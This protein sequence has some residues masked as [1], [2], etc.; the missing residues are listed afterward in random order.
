MGK[1]ILVLG[2]S[3]GGYHCALNLRKLLG[4]EHAIQVVSSDDTFT[5]VPSLPWVV[6]GWRE[7]S[8]IQFPVAKSLRRKGIEFICDTIVKAEPDKNKVTGKAGEYNYDYLVAATGSELDFAAIPGLGPEGGHSLCVFS[9]EQA[10]QAKT[11]LEKALDKGS[12]SIVVG[13]AQGASCLGP[14]Y[15]I[16]MMIDTHLRKKKIRNRFSLQLFT[17]EPYL[18]HFGVGGFGKVTRMLEDDFA[19][20]DIEWKVNSK[21]AQVTPEEVE[22]DDGSKY[23]NDFSLIVPAFYGS[24]AYM[25]IDGF[26]NPRGFVTADDYLANS[27]YQNVYAVGVSLALPPPFKTDV[28]V[29]VPKTGQMTEAMAK[30]AAYNIAVDIKGGAKKRGKDFDVICIA[31]AGD[32]AIY[33]YASPLLP[34]RNKLVHKKSKKAHYMKLAFEKYYMASLRYGLPNLDFGW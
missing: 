16:T 29:G 6:M 27:K 19:D 8:A 20:R 26:S 14:V 2:S 21:L 32:S 15:E 17:N 18:G 28:P 12:G 11:A 31:D 30:V 22:L 13:N 25:G 23:K 5:F 1:K 34:P 33:L 4:K 9:V 24:H 7:P 10:L 3:F